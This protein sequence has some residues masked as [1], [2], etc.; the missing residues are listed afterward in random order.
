[1]RQSSNLRETGLDGSVK[2]TPARTFNLYITAKAVS[3]AGDRV[4]VLALTFLVIRISHS[5]APAL[6]VF[7]L[8]RLLPTLLGGLIVGVFVDRYDRRRTMVVCDVG[9]AVL[10]AAVPVLGALTLWTLY[11]LVILLSIFTIVFDTAARAALPDVVSEPKM[12]RANALIQGVET[13]GDFAY[14]L[15]G[16]LIY[17]LGF[18]APFYL[19]AATFCIS[20][21]CVYGMRVPAHV[22]AGVSDWRQVFVLIREG[23]AHL[24]SNPFLK[25]STVVLAIAP[26]A[27]G[28]AFVVTPL[29]AQ[30]A[31]GHGLAGLG[32]LRSGAFRYGMVQ[33]AEAVGALLGVASVPWLARR[34]PRGTLFGLGVTGMGVAD[35]V[36]AFVTNLYGAM[37]ALLVAGAFSSIFVVCG[38]TLVQSLAPSELRGR[39]LAA[40]YT[41]LNAALAVG[42]ALGGGLLLVLSYRTLWLLDG[43]VIVLASAF[44]WFLP[45]VRNQS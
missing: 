3:V 20:A 44:V 36:L 19:N 34:M 31:L 6:S 28:V 15:G 40:R 39:V 2:Q 32:P 14:V 9:R 24:V 27:G 21:L 4:A 35:G 16:A 25:W 1:M 12:I 41:V 11:P 5:F 33:G 45:A 29:Y 7:Y 42:A 17:W 22:L 30:H 8:C 43:C 23:I 26:V 10:L 18:Q 13:A 37:G 38:I